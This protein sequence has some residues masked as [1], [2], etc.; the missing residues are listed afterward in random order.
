[1]N[2][3]NYKLYNNDCMN[4]IK[5]IKQDVI[6]I[7]PPWGGKNYKNKKNVNLFLSGIRISK[8]CNMFK[9]FAKYICLKVPNN[10]VFDEFYKDVNFDNYF[11]Y[12]LTKFH[13][14]ILY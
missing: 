14:I 2:F 7:D 8:I 10:F 11:K 3:K 12:D 5:T 13:I 9:Q 4:I 1:M 6:Y